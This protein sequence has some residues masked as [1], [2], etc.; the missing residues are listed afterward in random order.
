MS[1]RALFSLLLAALSM[2]QSHANA[3]GRWSSEIAGPVKADVLK[4][5]DGDT[6]LV[7]ARPWPQQI[8]EVYVRL[9]GID[10]PEIKSRCDAIREAGTKA[11]RALITML[12]SN[13]TV[14]LTR[15]SG[16]KYFGRVLAD[17]ALEDGRNP[18]QELLSAGFV[19]SYAERLETAQSCG[20]WQ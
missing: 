10:A 12:G 3:A 19:T 15:I 16:D 9:R 20:F 14:L 11:Q 8:I 2:G 18:A 13:R 17:V 6:I 4:V 7:A 5:V 1:N